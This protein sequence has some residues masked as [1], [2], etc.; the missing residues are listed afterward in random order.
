MTQPGRLISQSAVI[1]YRCRD[2][3]LQVLVI[4]SSDGLRWV[5]PKG[6]VEHDMTPAASAAKEALEE[7]GVTGRTSAAAVGTY[8]YGKWGGTCSVEVFLLRV[9]EELD[10]WQER[11][12]TREWVPLA[13]AIRRVTDPGLKALLG[14]VPGLVG[15]EV[16]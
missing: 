1:P 9:D 11:F 4:T 7:A 2:G 13:E 15:H 16:G 10:D 3:Q 14:R 12:R 6:L 8:T 5:V